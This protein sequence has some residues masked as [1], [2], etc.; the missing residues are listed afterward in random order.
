MEEMFMRRAVVLSCQGVAEGGGPFGAVVVKAGVIIG[1]GRNNVVP[2]QDPTQH[3]EVVAIR[4][5]C[6]ALGT[7]DLS[8][9]TLYTSCE[10]CP[11]CLA[12]TWWARIGEI[13]Y[14][15]DRADAARIGFDDAAIY[16]EVARPMP[17]RALPIRR[18]LSEEAIAAFQLWDAKP[19][20]IRY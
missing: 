16:E 20:K 13:V 17:A 14:G 2:G 3:A 18:L 19:D 11:M 7:H 6:A 15:N 1:E 4:A 5:A 8:G 10:P 12:A 9:A